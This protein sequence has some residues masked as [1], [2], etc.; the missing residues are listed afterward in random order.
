MKTRII[1]ILLISLGILSSCK[2]KKYE[3]GAPPTAA[4]AA[5]SHAPSSKSPNIID[6]SATNKEIIPIWDLGNSAKAQGHT[7][8]GVYPYA[9]T[10]TVKLTVFAKGGSA[11]STQ[12][13]TIAEDD[14]TLL[15]SPDIVNLTGGISGKGFKT[16]VI[17]ST[18]S[19][20]FGVGPEPASALG[21]VPEWYSAEPVQQTNMHF[22][23]DQYKFYLDGFKF[24]MVNNG[25]AFI[26]ALTVGEFTNVVGTSGDDFIALFPNQ[27]GESWNFVVED[28][29]TY[30]TV[31]GKS[32]IGFYAGVRKYQV[33]KLSENELS[34][35][36][37]D[38]NASNP[39]LAWYLRLV[40]EGYVPPGGGGG[41][42]GTPPAPED[43]NKYTL[44]IDFETIKPVVN[45]F[46]ETTDTIIPNPFKTGIDTSDF[47]LETTKGNMDWSGVF[48]NMK[49]KFDFSVKKT[50]TL[51]VYAPKTG[52]FLVK[53]EDSKN[54]QSVNKEVFV[55][56][57]KA[58]EWEQITADFSTAAAGTYDRLTLIPGWQDPN[59]G[60]TY[61]DD[62][63]Q[64]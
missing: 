64:K 27:L 7:A 63:E 54:G 30:L 5:F 8:Q 49:D 6:F 39:A 32:H 4:D 18:R 25:G 2:K 62:I 50:I 16:W 37:V 45:S 1:L 42:G 55:N 61:I 35:R 33:L 59:N 22:Y 41:G 58:N 52:Q 51:K 29:I 17:D 46:D 60:K 53:I 26:D 12:T 24:D 21:N 48:I 44:P 57:T 28:G 10:Y 36:Y 31:S 11:F 56:V 9:G 43:T 20:H 15:N 14:L 40:P 19:G 34:L 13:I 3:L 38:G 47:V 23:D